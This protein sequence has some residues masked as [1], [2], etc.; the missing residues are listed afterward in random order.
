MTFSDGYSLRTTGSA[1]FNA[2]AN[3]IDGA[4]KVH[5]GGTTGGTSTAYTATPSPAWTSTTR[6]EIRF[7]L[8][9]PHATNTGASTIDISSI[10]AVT[11]RQNNTALS[12]GELKINVPTLLAWDGTYMQIVGGVSLPPLFVDPANIRVGVG[13]SSPTST[14]H[15]TKASG[16]P[17]AHLECPGTDGAWYR[18]TSNSSSIYFGKENSAGNV[19]S[20]GAHASFM[21]S[22]GAYPMVL[23]SNGSGRLWIA[24]GGDVGFGASPASNIKADVRG[25]IACGNGSSDAEVGW[26]DTGSTTIRW[27]LSTRTDVGGSNADLKLLRYDSGGSYQGITFQTGTSGEIYFPEIGTTANAANSYMEST[28]GNQLLRCTSSQRYKQNIESIDP[29]KADAILSL[30]PVWYRS[31]ASHDREDWSYYGLIAEEVA[32]VEP[33]L[34]NWAYLPG[35]Y[36]EEVVPVLEEIE[37]TELDENGEPV[38]D[39][40]GRPKLKKKKVQR[41]DEQ[42]QPVTVKNK[43]LKAG[44][45]LVPDAVMYDRLGVLLLDVVKRQQ[46]KIESLEARLAALEAKVP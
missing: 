8:I 1:N 31:K 42:G 37:E 35:D 19:F 24:S 18:V 16:T 10:G 22:T 45:Q 33:R 27:N 5:W 15:I 38:L 34:V 17:D 40:K 28:N 7:L 43:K 36:E 6:S 2:T 44:A 11:V 39:K 20:L 3:A 4:V 32:A 30:R 46:Q 9:I 41:L 12:G 26:R 25:R 23:G 29:A 13:T 21:I 14:L